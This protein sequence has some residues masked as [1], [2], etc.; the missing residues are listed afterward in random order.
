MFTE[1]EI[2]ETNKQ[3]WILK[4][5]SLLSRGFLSGIRQITILISKLERAF[6]VEDFGSREAQN[7]WMPQHRDVQDCLVFQDLE[8][9]FQV[10]F[11]VLRLGKSDKHSC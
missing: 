9:S 5:I 6:E 7:S 3:T 4:T 2:L 11:Q 1:R 10:S 8:R